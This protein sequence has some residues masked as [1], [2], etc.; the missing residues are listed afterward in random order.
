MPW[1][2]QQRDGKVCVVK[3]GESDPV[4]G[5]C[6]ATRADAIKH[7]RALYAAESRMASMYAELDAEP[8]PVPEV[9]A[10]TAL[11]ASVARQ[12]EWMSE[13][14]ARTD[15]ALIATLQA[16]GNRE[17]VVNIHASPIAI[18]PTAVTVT[19]TPITVEA[20]NV[21]VE[22]ATVNVPPTQVTVQP[23]DVNVTLPERQK[24]VTFERD[25]LTQQVTKAEVV[26]T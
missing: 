16:L 5:G 11:A 6:H 12:M 26:E 24:T 19:P 23:A 14:Q 10:D 7:Q 18:E 22:A 25:P 1:Q 21:T 4:P 15:D 9:T 20:P 17:P 3:E 8:D 2:L 13:R